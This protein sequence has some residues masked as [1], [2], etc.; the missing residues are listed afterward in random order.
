MNNF[1]V[2]VLSM[3]AVY[4]LLFYTAVYLGGLEEMKLFAGLMRTL[5]GRMQ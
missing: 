1:S 5:T 2:V 4:M 3:V